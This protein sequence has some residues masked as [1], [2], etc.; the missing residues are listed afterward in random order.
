MKTSITGCTVAPLGLKKCLA[1]TLL[2]AGTCR[3]GTGGWEW[4]VKQKPGQRDGLT[5]R[6]HPGP[7]KWHGGH[8]EDGRADA[9]SRQSIWEPE[10]RSHRRDESRPSCRG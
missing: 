4:G 8:H 7:Y 9:L 2:E 3:T 6:S 10:L 1:G 5:H